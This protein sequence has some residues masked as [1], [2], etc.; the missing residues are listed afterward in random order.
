MLHKH[1]PN[2]NIFIVFFKKNITDYNWLI[3]IKT[4][5]SRS[6]NPYGESMLQG[7]VKYWKIIPYIGC[8]GFSFYRSNGSKSE[9]HL[10]FM[11]IQWVSKINISGSHYTYQNIQVFIR[12]THHLN[13][14]RLQSIKYNSK[15]CTNRMSRYIILNPYDYSIIRN[16]IKYSPETF[17]NS[18]NKFFCHFIKGQNCFYTFYLLAPELKWLLLEGEF[19]IQ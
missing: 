16:Y 1:F 18:G 8:K 3:Y 7:P 13:G 2:S 9:T 5:A 14:H 4:W 6:L 19:V 12:K 10:L 17:A 11:L 15:I